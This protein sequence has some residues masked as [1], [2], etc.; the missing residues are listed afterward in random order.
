M[1]WGDEE[2]VGSAAKVE[3]MAMIGMVILAVMSSPVGLLPTVPDWG[4]PTECAYV[5][6][7]VE[8]KSVEGSDHVLWVVGSADN[9][10]RL[11]LRVY[12]SELVFT[13][14]DLNSTYQGHTC[15]MKTLHNMIDNGTV[16]IVG[17]V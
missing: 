5:E 16:D 4:L 9:G 13:L 3:T 8:N 2:I 14:T 7:T 11:Q 6:G 17:V 1:G 15:Q 12:V 10:T